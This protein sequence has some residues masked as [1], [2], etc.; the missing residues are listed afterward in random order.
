MTLPTP[1]R[2]TAHAD[3][4][5]QG[6]ALFGPDRQAWRFICPSCSHIA[7]IAEWQMAGAP[8]GAVGFS[9]IG[10]FAGSGVSPRAAASAAFG[11]NGGPCNYTGGG[12]FQLNPVSIE[13][14]DAR[15]PTSFFEFDLTG[16]AH[17]HPSYSAS[18]LAEVK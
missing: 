2:G 11:R 14:E 15:A 7:S 18:A 12:L 5:R 8:E 17:E 3:W 6:E 1:H 9:C 10:R 16:A 13:F 4:Q